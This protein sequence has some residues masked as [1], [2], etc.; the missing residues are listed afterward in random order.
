MCKG[1]RSTVVPSPLF[2]NNPKSNPPQKRVTE[3]MTTGNSR[4]IGQQERTVTRVLAKWVDQYGSFK[5]RVWGFYRRTQRKEEKLM[6][7]K[8]A[9]DHQVKMEN[10]ESV[11]MQDNSRLLKPQQRKHIEVGYCTLQCCSNWNRSIIEDS[12]FVRSNVNFFS[13]VGAVSTFRVVQFSTIMET[14]RKRT[15]EAYCARRRLR[16]HCGLS[17]LSCHGGSKEID[18]P[19]Q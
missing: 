15:V 11:Q 4:V 2:G 16:V 3:V 9:T 8:N 14:N 10:S 19:R 18:V 13:Y 12:V 7:A 5:Y 6:R 1:Y 17:V